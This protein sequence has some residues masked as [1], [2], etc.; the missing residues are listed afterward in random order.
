MTLPVREKLS[1]TVTSRTCGGTI[2]G[3][4]Q[5]RPIRSPISLGRLICVPF[6]AKA[7][8]NAAIERTKQYKNRERHQMLLIDGGS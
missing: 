5:H 8:S 7:A 2:S 6:S 4:V 3:G 1:R